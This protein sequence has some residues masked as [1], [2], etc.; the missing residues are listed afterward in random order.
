[1]TASTSG[2]SQ[3]G[4]GN[5]V[6]V[7]G[8]YSVANFQSRHQQHRVLQS[9]AQTCPILIS[10]Q[11][12]HIY[13]KLTTE[14]AV[15]YQDGR[16]PCYRSLLHLMNIT[17][18]EKKRTWEV[19]GQ[20]MFKVWF[21]CKYMQDRNTGMKAGV[22]PCGTKTDVGCSTVFFLSEDGRIVGFV[23]LAFSRSHHNFACIKHLIDQT[24]THPGA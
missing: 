23:V 12:Q 5:V 2:P 16:S 22:N 10:E 17:R 4:G 19:Y 21:W 13:I 3:C 9:P 6:T 24:Q 8:P 11:G 1:M 14:P 18:A 7:T 20:L 15:L